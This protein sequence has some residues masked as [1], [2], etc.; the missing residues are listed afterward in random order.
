M[1]WRCVPKPQE[2]NPIACMASF[3]LVPFSNRIRDARFSWCGEEIQLDRNYPPEPHANH[4][5]GWLRSWRLIDLNAN[6]ATLSL[7][8]APDAS[9]PWPFLAEQTVSVH[10]HA[11]RLRLR[12][13][14]LADKPVPLAFGY[15]PYFDQRGARLSFR[16]ATVWLPGPDG[17]P[18]TGIAPA[19]ELY[20]RDAPRLVGRRVDHCYAN[21]DGV[22]TIGWV[23]KRLALKLTATRTLPFAVVYIPLNA[24]Y[25]CFEPV[26]HLSNALNSLAPIAPMPI[27]PAQGEFSA[28][29]SLRAFEPDAFADVTDDRVA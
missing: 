29:L 4:G 9:W 14:N 22:S 10:E 7:R 21:W 24:N 1:L 20:F 3:P 11:L 6:Q 2:Q 8:H 28:T 23:D 5:N 13:R 19:G 25:F 12:V 17:L 15:H 27:V 18:Q 16:A 26:P